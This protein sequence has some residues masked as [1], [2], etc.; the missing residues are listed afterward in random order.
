MTMRHANDGSSAKCPF[1]GGA[2]VLPTS[3]ELTDF[4]CSNC[5]M[6]FWYINVREAV[7]VFD[8]NGLSHDD[9]AAVRASI[10]ASHDDSITFVEKLMFLE[11]HSAS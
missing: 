7:F 10:P 4:P 2:V 6:L 5:G 8:P 11:S 1:C 3:L 9:W